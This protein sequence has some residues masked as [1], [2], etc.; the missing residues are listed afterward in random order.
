M[1]L[2]HE[3]KIVTSISTQLCYQ[4][5]NFILPFIIQSLQFADVKEAVN[6]GLLPSEHYSDGEIKSC[7][8]R[9]EESNMIM[10]ADD[11]VFL[12]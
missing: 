9:M 4:N 10:T 3:E 11:S 5:L 6:S 7:L 1:I 12:I 2:F 8:E